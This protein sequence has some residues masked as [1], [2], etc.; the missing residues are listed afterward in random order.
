MS[1]VDNMNVMV[2][3]FFKSLVYC[4]LSMTLVSTFRSTVQFYKWNAYTQ[5]EGL[6]F[7]KARRW[8]F[9]TFYW[10]YFACVC[11]YFKSIRFVDKHFHF[12]YKRKSE[13][14]KMY[15]LF[16]SS[17]KSDFG[18]AIESECIFWW[19]EFGLKLKK[20]RKVGVCWRNVWSTGTVYLRVCGTSKKD[21]Y[22]HY[23]VQ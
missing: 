15:T 19:C 6:T 21:V 7:L 8:I 22:I 13:E 2:L 18:S 3:R 14:G 10:F 23:L 20:R 16:G 17:E 5:V 1:L 4:L 9:S 12:T 11:C